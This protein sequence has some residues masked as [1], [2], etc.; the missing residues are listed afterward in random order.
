MSQHDSV[1][2]FQQLFSTG[3]P[4]GLGAEPRP[5]V[6][7]LPTLDQNVDAALRDLDLEPVA[8]EL[9]RALALLWHDHLDAAHA[10]AQRVENA[11]GAY[12]HGMMHRREADYW[13]AKYWFRRAGRLR[14]YPALACRVHG[15]LTAAQETALRDRV[16]PGGEWDPLAFVDA[17]Q[18][19]GKRAEFDATGAALRS[20]QAAEF[21]AV[22]E[23]LT[24]QRS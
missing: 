19:A 5:G 14:F 3:E 15:L 24:G 12:V 21:A 13:N 8:A 2:L 1:S 17:C 10:I 23:H 22:V 4:P 9:T 20:V 7:D 18:E 11:D 6:L 16:V